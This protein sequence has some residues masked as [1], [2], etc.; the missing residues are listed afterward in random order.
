MVMI[1]KHFL[2]KNKKILPKI[3]FSKIKGIFAEL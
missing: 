3:L 1:Q 2:K